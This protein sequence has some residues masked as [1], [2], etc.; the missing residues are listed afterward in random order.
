MRWDYAGVVIPKFNFHGNPQDLA[1]FL[2][3]FSQ[4]ND[5]VQGY[6]MTA[7]WMLEDSE[8]GNLMRNIASVIEKQEAYKR[9]ET[10]IE[11]F[12]LRSVTVEKSKK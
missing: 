1:Q 12:F 9:S 10:Y 2:W 7:E 4:V 11:D 8:D 3:Y 5:R 6:D